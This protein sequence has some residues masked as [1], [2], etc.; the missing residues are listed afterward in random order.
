MGGFIDFKN[1]VITGLEE[2]A[3]EL[4][5]CHEHVVKE[6]LFSFKNYLLTLEGNIL[7]SSI[8]ACNKTDIILDGHHRFHALKQLGLKKIPVTYV[9]YND[10]EIKASY[11]DSIT[12]EEILKSALTNNLFQPKSSKHVVFDRK[13]NR[14]MPIILLSSMYFVKI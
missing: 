7:I 12:K 3:V 8:I 9:N 14:Y 6:R 11:D 4:L 1:E 10:S 13:S 2:V 5:K